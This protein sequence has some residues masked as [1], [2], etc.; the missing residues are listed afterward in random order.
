MSEVMTKQQL[1]DALRSSG[2]RVASALASVSS[3]DLDRGR[4]D[5]GWNG[6]QILAHVASIEWTYPRLLDLA[7]SATGEPRPAPQPRMASGSPQ[8]ASYNARQVEKREGV[9]IA[10]LIAEF[11][12]N[13]AATIAAIEAADEALFAKVITS[14]GG[15]DGPLATVFHFVAVQHVLGHLADITDDD[16]ESGRYERADE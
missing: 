9:A 6:R 10:D 8:I 2:E 7:K 13:R 1:I 14:A 11:Q 4:Y 5:N 12:K 15:T 3:D 16:G